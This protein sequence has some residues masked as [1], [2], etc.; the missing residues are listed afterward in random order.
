MNASHLLAG[1]LVDEFTRAGVREAVISPGSRSG[2]LALAL[3]RAAQAGRLRLHV[4]IDERSAG[5]LAVG[6]AKRSGRP[7][8]VV[9]SSGTAAANLFPAIIEAGEAG[10]P[11][12]ALTADRPPELRGTGAN[13]TIDQTKLYGSAVRWFA[14]VA[15]TAGRDGLDGYWRSVVCRAFGAACGW[16]P[17]PVHLNVA[18][19]EPLGP[20]SAAPPAGFAG[21]P[22]GVPWTVTPPAAAPPAPALPDVERGVVV[23]GDGTPEPAAVVALARARGWP[24]IAEPTSNARYGPSALTAYHHLLDAPGFLPAHRPDLVVSVGKPGLSRAVLALLAAADQHLVVSASPRWP[25]PTRSGRGVLTGLAEA[26][27]EERPAAGPRQRR[28][29]WLTDWLAADRRVRGALDAVLDAADGPSEP[30]LARDLAAAL[31]DGS[32]LFAGSSMPIRYLDHHMRPRTGLTVIGNRGTSGIDGLVSTAI[33]AALAHPGPAAALLGDLSFLHD[34]NGLLI[35]ADEARPDLTFVV[36]DNDGGGIFSV[37]GDLERAEG[38]ERVFA[39]PPGRDLARV[40][41]AHRLPVGGADGR[42]VLG[43]ATGQGLRVV[44]AR[45]DRALTAAL[46]SRLREAARQAAA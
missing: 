12:L 37:L 9:C 34:Q 27:G 43:T 18:L 22:G 44:I 2:P 32:L 13:Q 25:D 31:P 33:G 42:A 38:F 20:D 36:V 26:V 19:P 28:S 1:V 24:L 7:A 40:A 4:R 30:A 21:R 46:G 3:H 39:T 35:G 41:A 10:V 8:I 29:A 6:L 14:E 17:G 45:S 15:A 5:Y 16:D 11:L 23:A